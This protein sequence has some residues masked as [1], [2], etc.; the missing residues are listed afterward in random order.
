[1]AVNL[2]KGITEDKITHFVSGQKFMG[3]TQDDMFNCKGCQV[4]KEK[5]V[6][7]TS[8]PERFKCFV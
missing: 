7:R 6:L 4:R 3:E 2:V 5:M 1:M 8:R